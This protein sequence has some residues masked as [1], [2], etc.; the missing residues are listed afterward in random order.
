LAYDATVISIEELKDRLTK[1]G[2][3]RPWLVKQTRYSENS[4]RQ[5]LGPKGKPSEKF[6]REVMRVI[7][8]EEARQK[9]GKP[10]APPWNLIFLTH[11]E[12]LRAD[13]ASRLVN[14]ES[15]DEFCRTTILKRAD[16][17]LKQRSRSTYPKSAPPI[18]KVADM[19]KNPD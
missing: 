13:Q 4:I 7:E 8:E 14:A 18:A 6:I 10:D 19:P 3:K 1:L 2:R 15:L 9:I 17:I 16:E 12:F 5:Y 11:E